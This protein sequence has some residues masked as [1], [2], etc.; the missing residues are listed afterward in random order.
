MIGVIVHD[1]QRAAT[2]EF[3]QLFK[4]PWEFYREGNVYPVIIT[5]RDDDVAS[6]PLVMVYSA[7]ETPHDI[8]AGVR[9]TRHA[10]SAILTSKELSVPVYA[11]TATFLTKEWPLLHVKEDGPCAAYRKEEKGQRICRIGYD[12]FAEIAY[13][14]TNGQPAAF[15]SIPAVEV[16]IALL[17]HL[18]LDAGLPIIEIPPVPY[19][20][21]FTVCL[22]HDVDF[23]RMRDHGFDHSVAGF[24]L[25]ALFRPALRDCRSRIRW[26]RLVDN[27]KAVL[28]IPFAYAGMARDPWFDID[29]YQEM[30]KNIPSTYFFVP[31][32]EYAGRPAD[33]DAALTRSY[34]SVHYDIRDYAPLV[35]VLAQ[36]GRE[37]A[38]HGIDT[39]NDAISASKEREVISGITGDGVP[40]VRMHWLYFT[41]RSPEIIGQAGFLYDSSVGYNDSVGFRSGT[42]QVYRLNGVAEV[43]ELPLHI[44]DTA[45]LLQNR[46][47]LSEHHAM[48]VCLRIIECF[49]T[50]GGVLTIN[51]HTRS[52]CP[53]RNWDSFYVEL[54]RILQEQKTWFAVA[55]Q[56][57]AWFR[58][59]RTA[60]FR[61]VTFKDDGVRI[62]LEKGDAYRADLP[63]LQMRIQLPS[64]VTGMNSSGRPHHCMSI[65][66]NGESCIEIPIGKTAGCRHA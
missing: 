53:E 3:F 41:E 60:R 13:L 61:A 47:G 10:G 1:D 35:R 51:W 58:L 45:L 49:R 23:I 32:K 52:L 2:E 44:M 42:T 22:T 36:E 31:Q 19:G 5:T 9:P 8:R 24:I 29:R 20:H 25:R 43:Y 21:D 6:A 26:S 12:L 57:V 7:K 28:A 4:T 40:G 14:L 59:R 39:W 17:R 37:I 11:G 62:E 48:Q 54:L 63:P 27:W 34:R 33:D 56:A 64:P 46:M 38:L 18:I 65:P 30:E 66:W 50:S 15:A 16:H 55:K